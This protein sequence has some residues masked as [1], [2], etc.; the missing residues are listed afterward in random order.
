MPRVELNLAAGDSTTGLILRQKKEIERLEQALDRLASSEA[1]ADVPMLWPERS[2]EDWALELVAR[3]K[4]AREAL[5]W[6]AA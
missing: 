1:F 2:R 3:L 6:D 4:F 5:G